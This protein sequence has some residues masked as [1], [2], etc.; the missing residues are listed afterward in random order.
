MSERQAAEIASLRMYQE[1]EPGLIRK[2]TE[3][4]RRRL[5]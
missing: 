4:V 1:L 3:A 2:F 5:R